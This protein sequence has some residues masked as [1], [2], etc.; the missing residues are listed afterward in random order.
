M[1]CLSGVLTIQWF[2]LAYPEIVLYYFVCSIIPCAPPA[3]HAIESVQRQNLMGL[4]SGMTM[5]MPVFDPVNPC[6]ILHVHRSNLVQDTLVQLQ[7]KH[8][9][10][11]KKPLKVSG[12]KGRAKVGSKDRAKGGLEV[13]HADLKTPLKVSGSKVKNSSGL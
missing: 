8:S 10:D 7:S 13:H 3:Q 5:P 2:F 11:L 12:S 9:A 6:L 4:F 1:S